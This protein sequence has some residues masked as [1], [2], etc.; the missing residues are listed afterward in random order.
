[1]KEE[2]NSSYKRLENK[3]PRNNLVGRLWRKTRKPSGC[4]QNL[5][6]WFG[7]C[8]FKMCYGSDPNR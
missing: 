5:E 3:T 8:F 2:E 4:Q 6:N 1:M 7:G